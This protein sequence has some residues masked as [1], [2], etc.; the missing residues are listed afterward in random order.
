[1]LTTAAEIVFVLAAAGAA[2]T[3]SAAAGLGGS[4]I[5]VPAL[6]LVLG[7]KEGIALAALLLALNNVVKVIAYRRTIPLRASAAVVVLT[8][9]G[10]A[11]GA[12]LL[13]R[14][15]EALIGPAVVVSIAASLAFERVA[16]LRTLRLGSAPV[17]AFASGATSGFSGTSGALKGVALRN[18]DLDRFRLAGAASAVSLA[19]DATKTAVFAD[20]ALLGRDAVVLAFCCAPLMVAATLLGRRLNR[21]VGERGYAVLF[22]GVMCGYS[23]RLVFS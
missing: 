16:S 15:S 1:M 11:V 21:D 23:A 5:L 8:V 10:A 17:L 18:L 6:A 13:V 19:A 3:V 20:A 4:L 14:A 2:F 22:W 9:L 12:S 7:A